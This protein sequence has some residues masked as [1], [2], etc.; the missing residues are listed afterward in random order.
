VPKYSLTLICAFLAGAA[1]ATVVP[2]RTA[3]AAELVPFAGYQG[4]TIV[5]KTRER[6][7]YFALG[8]GRAIRYPVGVGKAGQQWAGVAYIEARRKIRWAPRR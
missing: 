2:S 6:R 5:I 4:G 3:L 1:L 7:L 8:D